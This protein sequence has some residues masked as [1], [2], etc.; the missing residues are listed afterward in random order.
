MATCLSLCLFC[1]RSPIPLKQG[2]HSAATGKCWWNE[3]R[4]ITD[5]AHTGKK[6]IG[7]TKEQ[8]GCIHMNPTVKTVLTNLGG[9]EGRK[10]T[11]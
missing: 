7:K 4:A 5:V 8:F 11:Q 9:T 2:K 10:N 1:D 6:N 3:V